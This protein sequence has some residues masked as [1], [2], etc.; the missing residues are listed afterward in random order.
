MIEARKRKQGAAPG[1]TRKLREE[2]VAT[3]KEIKDSGVE[4]DSEVAAKLK[5]YKSDIRE[6]MSKLKETRGS[7]REY[8]K[9]YRGFVRE[10]DY[11]AMENVFEHINEVQTLRNGLL[12][13]I[14]GILS[15]M[16]AL[17]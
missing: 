12:E 2:Q 7:I 11:E 4:L 6:I 3:L 5:A 1:K 9:E 16:L 15:E 14:Y 17:I 13:E 10:L 8:L